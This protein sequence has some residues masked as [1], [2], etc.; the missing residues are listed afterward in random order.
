LRH[1]MCP[2]ARAQLERPSN[3]QIVSWRLSPRRTTTARPAW[4]TSG[5]LSGSARGVPQAPGRWL[6]GFGP[7][8]LGRSALLPAAS[9]AS[10]AYIRICRLDSAMQAPARR[11]A[12]LGALHIVF[13]FS[14]RHESPPRWSTRERLRSQQEIYELAY[15][16][17]A[18]QRNFGNIEGQ[19]VRALGDAYRRFE[20]EQADF[21][22]VESV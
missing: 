7:V 19:I 11:K 6:A 2:A 21:R 4:A 17:A 1:P 18:Q 22:P 9:S 5:L 12:F 16:Y 3:D 13:C 15:A 10:A 8:G 20:L 14:G